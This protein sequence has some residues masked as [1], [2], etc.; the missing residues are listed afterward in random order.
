MNFNKKEIKPSYIGIIDVWTYK[1]RVGICSILN[2]K[3]ELI[4]YGEKRQDINDISIQAFHHLENVCDNIQ[5]AIQKAERDAKRKVD[6]FMMHI[7]TTNVFF[8][9]SSIS[10]R[11]Q[12]NTEPIDE[13]E[14]YDLLKTIELQA[15]RKHYKKIKNM[16]WYSRSELKLIISN[17]VRTQID[18]QITKQFIWKNGD[19]VQISLVNIFITKSKY[20][21]KDYIGKYTG[22]EISHIIPSEYALAQL[23]NS[24]PNVVIIDLGNA[25]TSIIIKKNYLLSGVKKLSFGI[26]DLIKNIQKNHQQTRIEII[27]KLDSPRLFTQE[28]EEFLEIFTEILM[29]T[30]D[31]ILWFEICPH[32]FFMVWGGANKFICSHLRELDTNRFN[33]RF[34]KPITFI[35]PKIDFISDEISENPDWV[36]NAKTNINMYAMI[37]SSTD[38]IKKEKNKLSRMIQKIISEIN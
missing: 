11:R 23:F 22:K 3:I 8:E 7:P 1:V 34:T 31:D 30:I 29:I 25:H 14:A 32:K 13:S 36:Y 9:T 15:F 10:I 12:D 20:E 4:G 18:G 24:H 16:S 17:I 37:K 38:F 19:D 6:Q 35:E 28:K 21:I 26:H 27:K 33:V 2:K 5:Q